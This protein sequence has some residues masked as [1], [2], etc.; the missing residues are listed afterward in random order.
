M[1]FGDIKKTGTVLRK[2]K[3]DIG[4]FYMCIAENEGRLTKGLEVEGKL[5]F[6]LTFLLCDKNLLL[7]KFRVC[8]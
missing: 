1:K 4:E 2:Q 5:L 3:L 8:R 6:D 7:S